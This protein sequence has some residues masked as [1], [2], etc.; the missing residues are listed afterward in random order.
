MTITFL[1]EKAFNDFYEWT[2]S[3]K[4]IAKKIADLIKAINRTPYT[5]LGK[6]EPLKHSLSGYWSRHITEEHRLVYKVENNTIKIV[7]CKY[8]YE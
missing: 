7:S 1:D 6:P 3:D 5:G 8:H 2:T 4:K